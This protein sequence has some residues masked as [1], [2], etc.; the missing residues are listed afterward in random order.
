MR[1]ARTGYEAMTKELS[2]ATYP[3]RVSVQ[4]DRGIRAGSKAHAAGLRAAATAVAER[5]PKTKTIAGRVTDEQGEKLALIGKVAPEVKGTSA[6]LARAIE[7]AFEAAVA[8]EE[9][10]PVELHAATS[11]VTGPDAG[12]AKEGLQSPSPE[13][14]QIIADALDRWTASYN[15]L[16]KQVRAVGHQNNQ[17]VKLGH[18]AVT[19]GRDAVIPMEAVAHVG[20]VVE[21]TL[22]QLLQHAV[23]DAQLEQVIRKCL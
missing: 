20:Q 2:K 9:I 12:E 6:A 7:I 16:A 23:H 5:A 15:E 1:N 19:H 21:R 4:R 18:Q 17:L 8:A 14:A 22:D 13:A 3:R 11:A 10:A